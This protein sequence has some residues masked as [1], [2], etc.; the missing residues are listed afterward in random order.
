MTE[1]EFAAFQEKVRADEEE[2]ARAQSKIDKKL[3]K[4]AKKKE[5]KKNV[6][7]TCKQQ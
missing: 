1:S 4:R 7:D 2:K 3:E 6:Q 5:I